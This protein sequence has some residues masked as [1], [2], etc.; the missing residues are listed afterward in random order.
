MP[1]RTL[2]ET[3]AEKKHVDGKWRYA[4]AKAQGLLYGSRDAEAAHRKGRAKSVRQ[5]R[6]LLQTGHDLPDGPRCLHYVKAHV[7]VVEHPDGTLAV[8]QVPDASSNTIATQTRF[9]LKRARP[10]DPLLRDPK[11]PCGRTLRR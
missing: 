9:T 8:F 4:G 6:V 5:C 7:R 2:C 10:L 1:D 11:A 3:R